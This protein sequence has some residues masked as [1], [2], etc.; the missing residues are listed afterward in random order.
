MNAWCLIYL[1]ARYGLLASS[2]REHATDQL[3]QAQ[4]KV[5]DAG[6]QMARLSPRAR[7]LIPYARLSALMLLRVTPS[8]ERAVSVPYICSD[9]ACSADLVC[10]GIVWPQRGLGP[11]PPTDPLL[12]RLYE[13]LLVFGQPIKAVIHEKF[14]DGIMSACVVLSNSHH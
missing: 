6:G 7:I 9:G 10:R 8:S 1:G 2:V 13:V 3:Y 12:Y 4:Q 14:G 11:M 5:H